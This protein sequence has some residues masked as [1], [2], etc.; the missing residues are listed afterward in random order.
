MIS[1][2]FSKAVKSVTPPLLVPLARTLYAQLQKLKYYTLRTGHQT[3][4]PCHFEELYV[5]HNGDVYPC[6]RV[7]DQKRMKIG[8]IEDPDLWQKIATFNSACECGEYRLRKCS[9]GDKHNYQFLNIE[10]SLVCQGSCAMCCV[11]APGWK[12]SYHYFDSLNQLL[13]YCHPRELLLQ[14]GEILVQKQSLEWVRSVRKQFGSDLHISLVSNGNVNQDMIEIV[15]FLFNRVTLSIVGFQPQTYETIMG[16]D[17]DKVK[18]F[19]EQLSRNQ[20]VILYLKSLLSGI[21]EK[22][23][24]FTCNCLNILKPVFWKN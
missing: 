8:H 15:E 11:N 4:R 5:R 16:M 23:L 6:C 12:G 7:W 9:S 2:K 17:I 19:A 10:L 1:I 18:S 14:G 24:K 13:D 3:Q 20:K 21:S 22:Q